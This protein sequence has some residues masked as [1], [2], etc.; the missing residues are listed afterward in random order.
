MG[1]ELPTRDGSQWSIDGFV[2]GPD[3]A[4]DWMTDFTVRPGLIEEYV[5]STGA[6]LGSRDG[7]DQ[8]AATDVRPYGGVWRGPLFVLTHRPGDAVPPEGRVPELRRGRGRADRTGARSRQERRGPLTNDRNE[9]SPIRHRVTPLMSVSECRLPGMTDIALFHSVLGVRP[10]V[11]EAAD[12]LR[13]EG[14]DVVVVDQYGGRVF[15]DYEEADEFAQAIG[16]PT[17]MGLAAEAVEGLPDGLIAAGFSN[18]GGMAEFVATIRPVRG[19]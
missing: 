2:A 4:M 12:R 1:D 3:H 9:R 7:W 17:L 18:G 8:A 13:A 6:V 19:S 15:D 16:Y 14:H 11:S 5:T 10:G